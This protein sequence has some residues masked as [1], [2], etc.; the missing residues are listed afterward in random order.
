[1]I[2][3][4]R[5]TDAIFVDDL[6]LPKWV[7]SAFPER[8]ADIVDRRL[9]ENLDVERN[10]C[11]IA[12]INIGLLCTSESSQERPTMR[13]VRRALEVLIGG[14][15]SAPNL[16]RTISDL[17]LNASANITEEGVAASDSSTFEL[18]TN[19]STI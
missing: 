16:A 17:V 12:F 6:N 10:D 11:L 5:P 8:L 9:L 7:R 14:A 3:R 19:T 1:M 2:T 13:D 18:D 15:T 4:K